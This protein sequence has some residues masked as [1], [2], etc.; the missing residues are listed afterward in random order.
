MTHGNK[1]VQVKLSGQKGILWD[2]P[3][4]TADEIH[5]GVFS[6]FDVFCWGEVARAERR[7]RETG[8]ECN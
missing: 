1:H 7:Y 6:L 2:K 8:D 5:N 4:Y 3:L